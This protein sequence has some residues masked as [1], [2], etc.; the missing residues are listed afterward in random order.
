MK[1]RKVICNLCK[2]EFETRSEHVDTCYACWTA[3]SED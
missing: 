3:M 2:K 1:T